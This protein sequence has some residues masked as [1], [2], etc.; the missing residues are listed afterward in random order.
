M[1]LLLLLFSQVDL[2][3]PDYAVRVFAWE[4]EPWHSA[5]IVGSGVAISDNTV[6]TAYHVVKNRAS[7]Y[8]GKTGKM[9]GAHIISYNDEFDVALLGTH[10]MIGVKPIALAHANLTQPC[11]AGGFASEAFLAKKMEH[12][13]LNDKHLWIRSDSRL[14][15]NSGDSGGPVVQDGK[16]I[17]LVLGANSDK[18]RVNIYVRCAYVPSFYPWLSRK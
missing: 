7:M 9:G 6:L 15:T 14:L 8:T 10:T 17:G 1:I 3:E 2:K 12:L 11:W 18:E 16:L 5:R 13:S 4:G